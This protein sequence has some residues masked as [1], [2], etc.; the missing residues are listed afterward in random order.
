M[1]QTST[2]GRL[3][4]NSLRELVKDI[5]W[6]NG[7]KSNM[8]D[9]S[10]NVDPIEVD[11][12]I[13]GA[14][15]LLMFY[16]QATLEMVEDYTRAEYIAYLNDVKEDH[17]RYF[18]MFYFGA[19]LESVAAVT[20]QK[21][22]DLRANKEKYPHYE[23]KNDYHRMLY[24]LP[25]LNCHERYI[26]WYATGK[27]KVPMTDENGN[28]L[29]DADGNIMYKYAKDENGDPVRDELGNII[30][31]ETEKYE[32]L[33]TLPFTKRY[34]AA[35]LSLINHFTALSEKDH[36]YDYVK[37]ML[38][39]RIHPFVSRLAGRFDLLYIGTG[40]IEN[41][42][43]DFKEV[44][45]ECTQFM[46][47]RYYS[48]AYRN[49]YEF[50]EGFVGISILFMTLQRM[51]SKY[52]EADITRDF[53]DLDS[54]KVV[55]DAYSVPFF[56]DI[57]ITY[58]N[59]IIKA[60][61]RLIS[62]KGSNMSFKEL[63]DIFEFASLK[64]YQYYLL[65]QHIL[66]EH[67]NPLFVYDENGNLDPRRMYDIKFVQGDIGDTP[68]K[69]LIDSNN[70]HNYIGVTSADPYWINDGP[71]YDKIYDTEYNFIETKYIG[72]RL[73]YSLTR[74]LLESS[75]FMRMLIDNRDNT[76]KIQA[77]GDTHG[78]DIYTL[79][80]YI[81]AIICKIIGIDG[82]IK[83]YIQDPTK[84][85]A[86]YGYN[87][88]G[89]LTAI[90]PYLCR[91]FFAN[92]DF[93]AVDDSVSNTTHVTK[94][95]MV[96]VWT[97]ITT[98]TENAR[99]FECF[100]NDGRVSATLSHD[101][102]AA[103]DT[104]RQGNDLTCKADKDKC[105]YA[106]ADSDL[107]DDNGNLYTI[108]A[109]SLIT[110]E[111]FDDTFAGVY[112]AS[113][114]GK[115]PGIFDN[116][117]IADSMAGG[118]IEEEA[119]ERASKYLGKEEYEIMV[120][121]YKADIKSTYVERL[122]R[123]FKNTVRAYISGEPNIELP[124][125]FKNHWHYV[126]ANEL[127]AISLVKNY[128]T[129]VTASI[130]P[131]DDAFSKVQ[132][133]EVDPYITSQDIPPLK[134][135]KEWLEEYFKPSKTR[136]LASLIDKY[137]LNNT[138]IKNENWG[139]AE[140]DVAGVNARS[141]LESNEHAVLV[142]IMN[143]IRNDITINKGDGR[144]IAAINQSYLA[145]VDLCNV[146]ESTSRTN[147]GVSIDRLLWTT[148]NPKTYYALKRIR[149]ML[150]TTQIA[151]DAY[152]KSNGKVADTYYDLLYDLNPLLAIEM[153][154]MT[155]NQLFKELDYALVSIKKLCSELIYIQSYG[156]VN[157]Q[158]IIDYIYSL[159][160]FFKSAKVE[161]IDFSMQY[162]IDGRTT[163]LIKLMSTMKRGDV[164]TTLT[165]DE[166]KMYDLISEICHEVQLRG[167]DLTLDDY[168]KLIYRYFTV[169][170][171]LYFADTVAGSH[172]SLYSRIDEITFNDIMNYALREA[173]LSNKFT[174]NDAVT[175]DQKLRQFKLA[176]RVDVIKDVDGNIVAE[177]DYVPTQVTFKDVL[178]KVE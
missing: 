149:Q 156:S 1:A 78:L 101:H 12:Y 173:Q 127:R 22:S 58:H 77:P 167:G 62:Y 7:Y 43:R 157:T 132:G 147:R 111:E 116:M 95:D 75:Y 70:D 106:E 103:C 47:L 13:S 133:S 8:G 28:P 88:V 84:M 138:Y 164:Y 46:I 11:T 161:L 31:E 158:R 178:I 37:Y 91:Q 87:F 96:N 82:A 68:Y 17:K 18:D 23:E 33:H 34:E 159:I 136:D 90:Y 56:E 155:E 35:A 139:V 54:I 144:S 142:N 24:G 170:G 27:T 151:S 141:K 2:S 128:I 57:P 174:I 162:T 176:H 131:N 115:T 117:L 100:I 26:I 102:C 172:E 41:L 93:S 25:P 4:E 108:F 168:A 175:I 150:L 55:Y 119:K 152:R 80:I 123:D 51:Q 72:I 121:K 19:D 129:G 42:T 85:A 69:Y 16:S 97:K 169:K 105:V 94:G 124:D 104:E 36:T 153:D 81:H 67:G 177:N 79:V 66:D 148:K 49:Q 120:E 64:I 146:K 99:L 14:R 171:S 140:G 122:M 166:M 154:T 9:K 165:P 59:K 29:K 134:Y 130:D 83:S 50:Y 63:F 44:Y 38:K 109:E 86:V 52:L 89:D 107:T 10:D 143:I 5:V 53:Y 60:I 98:K 76:S 113:A 71:L 30:Y 6:K 110:D 15:Y 61:N 92:G 135:I 48:E 74:Y 118:A 3:F 125:Y 65:K 114:P 145:I 39:K 21:V 32:P 45:Q 126:C 73:A 137:F 160:R 20:G 163:N 40:D 112:R